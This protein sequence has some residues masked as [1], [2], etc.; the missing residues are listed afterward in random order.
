M[1]YADLFLSSLKYGFGE[2]VG[3]T[4]IKKSGK[5][6]LTGKYGWVKDV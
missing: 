5:A 3:K 2:P 4:A 1:R 6:F